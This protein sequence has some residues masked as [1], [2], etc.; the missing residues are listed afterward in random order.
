MIITKPNTHI[1]SYKSPMITITVTI[2]KKRCKSTTIE[3][4]T[5]NKT[6]NQMS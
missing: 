5:Q 2:N 3:T 1:Q 6:S 4:I